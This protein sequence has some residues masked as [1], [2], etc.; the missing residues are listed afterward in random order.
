MPRSL[1]ERVADYAWRNRT[2]SATLFRSIVE[3]YAAGDPEPVVVD[4]DEEVR[5]KYFIPDDVFA[6]AQA[7]ATAENTTVSAVLRRILEDRV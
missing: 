1:R 5:V 7:R 4:V 6:A 2:Q 3:E